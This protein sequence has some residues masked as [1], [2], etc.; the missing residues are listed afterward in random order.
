[1]TVNCGHLPP[2]PNCIYDM[3]KGFSHF[4]LF[5]VGTEKLHLLKKKKMLGRCYPD[6]R[7][8]KFILD[9]KTFGFIDELY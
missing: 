2:L 8:L 9:E 4:V 3:V 6:I 1:M 7:R 5:N